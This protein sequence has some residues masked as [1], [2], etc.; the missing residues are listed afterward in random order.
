[1]RTLDC[2]S[3]Q[4]LMSPFIDS[5]VTAAEAE[6]LEVHIA[7][8]QACRRQLQSYKSIRSLLARAE[9]P[10]VPED[11]VLDTR[12]RLSQERNKNFLVRFENRLGYVLKP[13]LV[14]A[15]FGVSLT[16]LFFAT[17]LGSFASDSTV[18]AQDRPVDKPVFGLYQ[19][20][21]TTDPT[22]LRFASCDDQDLDEP[23]TI[24][25]KVGDEGRVIDYE[26]LSGPQS[27]EVNGWIRE[28][29]SL[30][31]FMPAT[32]F[33]RPIESKIILSFVAVRN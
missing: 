20:V 22:M 9:K 32:A 12:V 2:S 15:F 26:V 21:R 7:I 23:L 24:E 1:M 6:H 29:M 10:A 30:A 31:Q 17:L 13:F 8:C 14:P 25:T 11:M 28:M 4:K 5:M 18:L 33:G 16:V 3:A 19:P 27:P